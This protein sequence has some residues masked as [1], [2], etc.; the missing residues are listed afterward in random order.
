MN[1]E[2]DFIYQDYYF[3]EIGAE[4]ISRY[5]KDE[6]LIYIEEYEGLRNQDF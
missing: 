1:H 6:Y 3:R 5:N 2:N 4:L